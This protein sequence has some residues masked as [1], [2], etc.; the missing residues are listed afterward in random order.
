MTA[1]KL[2]KLKHKIRTQYHYV[3]CKV[4]E[5]GYY[6]EVLLR[7]IPDFEALY[8]NWKDVL[9]LDERFSKKCIETFRVYD[10]ILTDEMLYYIIFNTYYNFIILDEQEDDDWDFGEDNEEM[11]EDLTYSTCYYDF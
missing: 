8:C 11:I 9:E 10:T 6:H 2:H 4:Y 1:C 7:K 3:F 5:R